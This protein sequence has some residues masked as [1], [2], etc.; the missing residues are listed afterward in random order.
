MGYRTLLAVEQADGSYQL[1]RRPGAT[2]ESQWSLL[3]ADCSLDQIPDHIDWLLD[4][5]LYIC[6]AAG[7]LMAFFVVPLRVVSGIPDRTVS[8]PPGALLGV[9][10]RPA[11]LR[12][13]ITAAR[14][15]G[16]ILAEQTP[17][18]T[19]HIERGLRVACQSWS[20]E[21]IIL[22]TDHNAA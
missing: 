13:W 18:S 5:L 12:E 16:S 2:P 21:C 17:I 3:A 1:Y 4:E 8:S 11:V 20:D 22:S 6:P 7:P 19:A 9:S 10:D 15:F 14:A